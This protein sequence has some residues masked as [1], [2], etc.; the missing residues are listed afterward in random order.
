MQLCKCVCVCVCHSV[1]ESG[2]M[3]MGGSC[4]SFVTQE[5]VHGVSMMHGSTAQAQHAIIISSFSTACQIHHGCTCQ[6]SKVQSTSL[7]G[8]A[9]TVWHCMWHLQTFQ[10]T[11]MCATRAKQQRGL[12]H[13]AH[14]LC[15]HA[16]PQ[17]LMGLTPHCL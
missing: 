15:L 8:A 5:S 14:R 6:H 12:C 16:T 4:S 1:L 7:V 10:S 9:P 13:M 3:C 2:C 17:Q 11:G